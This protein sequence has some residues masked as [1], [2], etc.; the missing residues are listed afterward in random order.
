MK[1]RSLIDYI[2]Q[3]G[4]LNQ[5]LALSQNNNGKSVVEALYTH[6]LLERDCFYHILHLSLLIRDKAGDR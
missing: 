1:H 5:C 3:I 6:W 4:V 2:L